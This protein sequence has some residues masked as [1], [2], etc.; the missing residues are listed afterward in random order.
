MAWAEDTSDQLLV[1]VRNTGFLPDV[2]DQTDAVLARFADSEMRTMIAAAVKKT[3]G[4]FWFRYA[5]TTIVPGTTRYRLPRRALAYS[6]QA[7][8]VLDAGGNVM[9][10]LVEVTPMQLRGMFAPGQTADPRWFAFEDEFVNLGAVPASSGWTLR[11]HYLLR[12][13]S[14]V[15]LSATATPKI[16]SAPST[17]TLTLYDTAPDSDFTTNASFVDIVRGV[18]P[19]G[20]LYLDRVTSS[21]ANPTLTLDSQTPIVVA[22]FTIDGFSMYS[23]K[24]GHEPLFVTKR[25]QTPFPM[26]PKV[27]WDALVHGVVAKALEAVRDPGATAMRTIALAKLGEGISMMTPRDQRN[28]KRIISQSALRVGRGPRRSWRPE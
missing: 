20:P 22:D 21:Y 1:D 12:P 14:L 13:S 4:E 7:V 15:S 11:I 24:P 17:T 10:P 26:I 16:A 18:E 2:S 8:T 6:D 3:R 19:Y 9:P 25:D 28:S 27:L 5:D 23:G